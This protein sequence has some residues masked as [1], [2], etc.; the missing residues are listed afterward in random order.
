VKQARKA[1]ALRVLSLDEAPFK[2]CVTA[3]GVNAATGKSSGLQDYFVAP[4]QQWI[5]GVRDD[6]GVV[7]QFQI[8][9][10]TYR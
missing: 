1:I 3:G 4:E 9:G 10:A 2:F 8:L 5:L 7:R 6:D